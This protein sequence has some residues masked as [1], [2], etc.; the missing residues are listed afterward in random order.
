MIS[1]CHECIFVH[2][3]K[4]GGQSVEIAFLN[5]LGLG[6]NHRS[7]LLL[8]PNDDPEVGPPRLAHLTYKQYIKFNYL[9]ERLWKKY[10][11]FTVVRN[12]YSRV[13]SFYKYLGFDGA[14]SFNT[15]V[16]QWLPKLFNGDMAWF[17]MPQVEYFCKDDGSISVD[18]VV[19]LEKLN[20]K[21]P[22]LLNR[23]GIDITEIPHVN[24]SENSNEKNAGIFHRFCKAREGVFEWKWRI[25]KDLKWSPEAIAVANA[26]YQRDFKTLEYDITAS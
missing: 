13:E 17:L 24:K 11:S 16:T 23:V 14:V 7:P 5:D 18:E 15:F 1:H 8:R 2:I 6:W 22:S 26:L 9:S 19:K 20:N 4:C 3:P 25:N 21:L 10:F 12:P